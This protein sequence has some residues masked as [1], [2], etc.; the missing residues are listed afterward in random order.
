MRIDQLLNILCILKSR[1]LAKK[2]C[3]EGLVFVNSNQAKASTS[4]KEGDLIE[5][6][7]YGI[8]K[9]IKLLKMPRGNLSKKNAP[10]YYRI[11]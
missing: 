8:R 5:Y 9:K 3:D 2:I 4:V 10:D 6:S 7:L 1:S 11:I